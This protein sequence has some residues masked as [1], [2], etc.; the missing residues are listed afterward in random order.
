M[1]VV[2]ARMGILLKAVSALYRQL[3]YTRVPL[4][5]RVPH[6]VGGPFLF[7]LLSTVADV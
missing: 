3:G 2:A 5:L 7:G 1:L 4:I 6:R